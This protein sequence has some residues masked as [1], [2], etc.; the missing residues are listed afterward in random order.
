MR[1]TYTECTV[2]VPVPVC[3]HHVPEESG[4]IEKVLQE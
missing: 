3:V 2:Y 4:D 1:F